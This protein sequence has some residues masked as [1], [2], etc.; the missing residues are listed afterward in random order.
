MISIRSGVLVAVNLPPGSTSGSATPPTGLLGSGLLG[1]TEAT[2]NVASGDTAAEGAAG[3]DTASCADAA[4]AASRMAR[5]TTQ[6]ERIIVIST[7]QL[8]PGT[9]LHVWRMRLSDQG[10]RTL[11]I[12]V[13]ST[14]DS[15]QTVSAFGIPASWM[16]AVRST[17]THAAPKAAD[18]TIAPHAERS[19]RSRSS[20]DLQKR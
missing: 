1:L 14:G 20:S 19:V 16:P 17:V 10:A 6:V 8:L 7:F 5:A 13:S 11:A 12:R 3:G 15:I 4:A 9:L 18:T 2:S